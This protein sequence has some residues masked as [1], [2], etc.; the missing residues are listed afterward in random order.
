MGTTTVG[1]FYGAGPAGGG[2]VYKLDVT[3]IAADL[4]RA[5]FVRDLLSE[6]RRIESPIGSC[7]RG[8]RLALR[9]D[10]LRRPGLQRRASS[11]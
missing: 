7:Q 9:R 4:R 10:R 11:R 1:G 2:I 3:T 8:W 5:P 6:R